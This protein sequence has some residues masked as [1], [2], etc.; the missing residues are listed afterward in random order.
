MASSVVPGGKSIRR[1]RFFVLER[2]ILPLA[3]PALRALLWTW[4]THWPGPSWLSEIAARPRVIFTIF[5]GTLFA[6]LAFFAMWRPHGRR[7]VVL[8]TPS[9]DGRFA[10]A[11]LARCGVRCAPLQPGARGSAAAREFIDRVAAGDV[12]V[13][14]VDGPR[15]PRGVVKSGVAH[16]IAAARADVVAAGLAASAGYRF[17]SWDRIDLPAP[18]AHVHLHCRL[19]PW[20]AAAGVLET[21]AIQ[22][23]LDAAAAAAA[24]AIDGSTVRGLGGSRARGGS[25][26]PLSRPDP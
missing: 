21:A 26:L 2:I 14:L 10:A 23:A 19:L 7:W 6:G 9:L 18:F 11:M 22:A 4:R 1:L 12:G 3:F 8:T 17:A 16:T 25:T 13:I 24:G 5:H 15:G 20:P